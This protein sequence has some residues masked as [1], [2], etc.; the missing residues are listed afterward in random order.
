[1]SAVSVKN[2]RKSYGSV[3]AVGDVSFTVER[4]EV[5]GLLGPNGVGKPITVL[6]RS[7]LRKLWS[8]SG[9]GTFVDALHDSVAGWARVMT[10]SEGSPMSSAAR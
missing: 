6:R 8:T 10:G 7:W 4:G 1:V 2:L 3:Q 9:C 5:F